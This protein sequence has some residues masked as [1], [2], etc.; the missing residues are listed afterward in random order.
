MKSYRVT[1]ETPAFLKVGSFEIGHVLIG[2]FATYFGALFLELIISAITHTS[3]KA[4]PVGYVITVLLLCLG[5]AL[6]IMGIAIIFR[7]KV[8]KAWIFN[9]QDGTLIYTTRTLFRQAVVEQ[10]YDLCGIQEAFVEEEKYDSEKTY[11]AALKHIS[12]MSIH[13]VTVNTGLWKKKKMQKLTDR[14]NAWM[15]PG[16]V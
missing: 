2:L 9:R 4:H 5:L 13:L 1:E 7:A 10:E 15:R 6:V 3:G 11:S 14:I 12:G 16:G 8:L